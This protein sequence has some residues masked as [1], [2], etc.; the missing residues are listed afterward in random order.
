MATRW[1]LIDYRYLSISFT[2]DWPNADL[3]VEPFTGYSLDISPMPLF[4]IH[5]VSLWTGPFRCWHFAFLCTSFP[6][7]TFNSDILETDETCIYPAPGFPGL[8]NLLDAIWRH[9]VFECRVYSIWSFGHLCHW[10]SVGLLTVRNFLT[11]TT[12]FSENFFLRIAQ[13]WRNYTRFW[14]VDPTRSTHLG[15]GLI[16]TFLIAIR[17]SKNYYEPTL[18]K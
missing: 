4:I 13:R 2:V 8:P 9:I 3:P 11:L 14:S 6:N 12:N 1:F 10:C 5:I 7:F 16:I 15:G 18:A 17:Y